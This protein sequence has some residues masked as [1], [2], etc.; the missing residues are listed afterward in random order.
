MTTKK[1]YT[2]QLLI[3][4]PGNPKDE[5][6]QSVM[7][8]VT[9]TDT[10]GVGLQINNPHVDLTLDRISENLGIDLSNSAPVYYGGNISQN[11]IHII[12][13]LDWQGLTTVK[14]TNEIG[15][16]NDISV[17]TAMARGEGPRHFRACSG[18]WLWE[19]GRL[20]Q[21]L[22]PNTSSSRESHKW[23]VAPATIS[24]VFKTSPSKQWDRA[25]EEAVKHKT[26]A[27]F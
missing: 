5:L 18:Y 27:L 14:L 13:S 2:G 3:A 25:I 4:N 21:Q 24:N 22:D 23:E 10:T 20:D 15:I 1:K 17:L 11:K 26:A 19:D 9:H 12:H 8:I 7:L 16:T 6:D